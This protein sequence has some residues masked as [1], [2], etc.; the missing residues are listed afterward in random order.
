MVKRIRTLYLGSTS[1]NQNVDVSVGKVGNIITKTLELACYHLYHIH[2]L[3]VHYSKYMGVSCK[4]S[5][6]PSENHLNGQVSMSTKCSAST[7]DR[8]RQI[9]DRSKN[10]RNLSINNESLHQ[11]CFHKHW[12][13]KWF[14]IVSE[15]WNCIP[16]S[17]TLTPSELLRTQLLADFCPK[18]LDES[19]HVVCLFF[20]VQFLPS[21]HFNPPWTHPSPAPFHDLDLSFGA[22]LQL[23][24]GV[25]LEDLQT[26][27]HR[28]GIWSMHGDLLWSVRIY[29]IFGN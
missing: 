12:F 10:L 5:H 11:N 26:D 17:V 27:H 1:G 6:E 3:H 4:I 8:F 7:M 14:Y 9:N 2:K 13:Y 16:G 15:E 20:P 29:Y 23:I 25:I 28:L 21:Q 24:V 22:Q 19:C 18:S